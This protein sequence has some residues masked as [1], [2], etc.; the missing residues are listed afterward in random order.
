MP[1]IAAAPLPV[2]LAAAT[3]AAASRI[4]GLR[5]RRVARKRSRAGARIGAGNDSRC[6]LWLLNGYAIDI[7][8]QRA[9]RLHDRVAV[10]AESRVGLVILDLQLDRQLP[11]RCLQVGR[12]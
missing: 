8:S 2:G 1:S 10:G 4:A 11:A 9:Q 3:L 5:G 12:H 7:E 6:G